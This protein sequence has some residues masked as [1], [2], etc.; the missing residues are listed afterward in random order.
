MKKVG[1]RIYTKIDRPEKSKVELFRN[2]PVANIADSMGRISCM[3]H[4]IKNANNNKLLGIAFTIKVPVG[5][6]L[7]IHK[8]LDMLQEGDVLIVDR[9]GFCYV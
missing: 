1:C 9:N 3:D 6:N 5:D 7:M 2:V 8:A 4:A